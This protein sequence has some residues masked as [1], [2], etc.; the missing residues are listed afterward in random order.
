MAIANEWL[1]KDPFARFKTK[2]EE[3]PR[4]FLSADELERIENKEFEITRLDQ[5]RDIFVFS[6]YTGLA[7][8]DVANL[9]K[10]N[11]QI[12]IDGNKWI[13]TY[14]H[15]TKTKS[16]IP[17]LPKAKEI[18]EKYQDHPYTAGTNK[19]LPTLSNQKL[20]SYL[21]EIADKKKKVDE[22]YPSEDIKDA[23]RE[24]NYM[25]EDIWK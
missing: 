1:H 6:C 13:Y 10:D 17:L 23:K 16:N 9:T 3:V 22:E 18:I 4:E 11:I 20:N 24:V 2:L 21:K 15:K 25:M 14:R 19:L 7:Y 8:V 5:V 12:G